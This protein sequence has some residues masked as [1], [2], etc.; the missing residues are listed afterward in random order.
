M[1]LWLGLDDR[2]SI[3][4]R[5]QIQDA[6]GSVARGSLEWIFELDPTIDL[7]RTGRNY[8]SLGSI[9]SAMSQLL[10]KN[11]E[12]SKFVSDRR[13]WPDHSEDQILETV[14]ALKASYL[15]FLRQVQHSATGYWGPWYV[16]EDGLETKQD[17]SFTFHQVSYLKGAVD[18][19]PNII[20]TTLAI[21][22]QIY[23]Y[24]WRPSEG[25][26]FPTTIITMC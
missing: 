9:E 4:Q 8:R 26:V 21:K 12:L 6:D 3:D 18:H 16:I 20:E 7:A 2:E 13:L 25:S 23:P 22:D 15:D 14:E 17:L 10:F 19:W 1:I 24:G 5:N 11:G